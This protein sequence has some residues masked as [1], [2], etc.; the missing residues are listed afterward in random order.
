M[1]GEE[2]GA[3]AS[4]FLVAFGAGGDLTPPQRRGEVR[5]EEG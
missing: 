3:G 4:S 1:G 2:R 5:T